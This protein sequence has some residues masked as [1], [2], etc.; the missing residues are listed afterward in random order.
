MSLSKCSLC[1]QDDHGLTRAP[2]N[3]VS[4]QWGSGAPG[5]TVAEVAKEGEIAIESKKG[6]TIKKNADPEN[7]AVHVERSGND[8]VKRASELNVEEKADGKKDDEAP[9]TGESGDQDEEL[10]G[11]GEKDATAGAEKE[12]TTEES[13][14]DAKEDANG[15]EPKAG[16]KRSKDAQENG[17]KPEANGEDAAPA[18]EEKKT[19]EPAAKKQKT[20]AAKSETNGKTPKKA[21][22]PKKTD[23]PSKPKK[24]PKRAATESGEPRRSSRHKA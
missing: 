10:K 22:R 19:D 15:E 4:W 14:E 1:A 16:E 23:G 12:K 21:G 17:E 9:A 7:P 24:E 8:V 3:P 18:E 11:N 13:K 5:G 2:S 6:N 20:E